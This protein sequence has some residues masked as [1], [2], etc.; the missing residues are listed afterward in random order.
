MLEL[1]NP[2][3]AARWLRQRVTGQLQ[4]DSRN[5]KSGDGF[6]AWPGASAD[7]RLFVSLARAQGAAACIV[8]KHGLDAMEM[9]D[10]PEIACFEGLKANAGW[11]ANE[12]YASPSEQLALLAVT[13]T[14]GKTS[15]TWWLAQALNQLKG[16]DD[17]GVIGTLGTGVMSALTSTGMTTPDAVLLQSQLREFADQKM[18]YVAMEVSSIGI[19]EHRMD[20]AKVRVAVFTNLTQDHLDY[21]GEMVAYGQAKARLFAWPG[22]KSCVINIA[23]PFGAELAASLQAKGLDIWTCSRRG[24]HG[25]LQA[26]QVKSVQD[27]LVLDILEAG[28]VASLQTSLIGDFN[29]DNLLGVIGVLRAL[30]Y[31][32]HAAVQA[33]AQLS[34][35][36][37][38]MQLILSQS[39]HLPLAV[40]DYAHTPDAV[41]KALQALKNVA[42]EREGQLWCVMGC[43][44]DRDPS[45][46]P[47]MTSAA[48]QVADRVVLTSDNP[49][50]EDPVHILEQ[51]S[52]G[53]RKPLDARVIVDR[54][55]AIEKILCEAKPSDVVLI[56]GKGHENYQDIGGV[57]H[58]FSDIEHAQR[59]LHKL[60]LRKEGVAS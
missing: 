51:M 4:T 55:L 56:A 53:M 38:R 24:G 33:C 22:L 58:P 52:L 26:H 27:G 18:T 46:R 16:V 39:S 3:E 8:E 1:H 54:A 36:P 29:I 57:R 14:N 20:G 41:A 2:I 49:R 37:G 32:L 25:R 31:P 48:E 50:T 47:L 9:G 19:Q 60:A 17:C 21:H 6:L 30:G 12:F 11:I 7:G 23:D 15:T 5:V 42:S 28:Q 40:V 45:K 59:V 13:G 34:P 43:G 35:V 44:G 10:S